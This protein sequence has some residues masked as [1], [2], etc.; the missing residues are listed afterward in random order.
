MWEKNG[1]KKCR[2]V[3]M[4]ELKCSDGA[5]SLRARLHAASNVPATLLHFASFALL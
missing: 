1:E 5:H 2:N 3:I 4:A